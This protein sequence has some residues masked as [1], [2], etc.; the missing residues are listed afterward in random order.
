MSWSRLPLTVTF[1]AY[2][3][4]AS[5]T[6]ILDLIHSP[7]PAEFIGLVCLLMVLVAVGILVKKM[8]PDELSLNG[9]S[10]LLVLVMPLLFVPA[11]IFGYWSFLG[12]EF[13][14]FLMMLLSIIGMVL[15]ALAM[16]FEGGK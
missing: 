7:H 5:I 6:W 15:E 13:N 16:G 4:L 2:T 12:I 10:T 8:W 1:G 3:V 14:A 11:F 9:F